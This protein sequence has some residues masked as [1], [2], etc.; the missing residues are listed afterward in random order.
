MEQLKSIRNYHFVVHGY[1]GIYHLQ[2]LNSC[3]S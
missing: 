1:T 2:L 3:N